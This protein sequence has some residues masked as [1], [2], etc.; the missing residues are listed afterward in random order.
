MAQHSGTASPYLWCVFFVSISF[1]QCLF[2]SSVPHTDLV[3]AAIR[4]YISQQAL[5]Y[6]QVERINMHAACTAASVPADV[7]HAHAMQNRITD[8]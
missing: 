2:P 6:S 5:P 3:I 1:E 4:K 7:P 8:C